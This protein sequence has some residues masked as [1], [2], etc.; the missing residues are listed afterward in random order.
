MRSKAERSTTRSLMIGNGPAR[1]GSTVMVSPSLKRAHAHLAGGGAG[2]GAVGHAV[3]D[4]AA[5][6]ADALAAV[7]VELDGLFA[8]LDQILVQDVEHL[9]EGHLRQHVFDR[10]VDELALLGTAGLPPDLQVN[11]H[12]ALSLMGQ[13]SSI[14]SCGS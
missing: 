7:V 4:Q 5:G 3:D 8:L 14:C 12:A 6:A 13:P 1:N 9:E 11:R 10:V 2:V